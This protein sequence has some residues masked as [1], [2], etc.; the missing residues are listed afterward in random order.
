M[1]KLAFLPIAPRED[2]SCLCQAQGVLPT[3]SDLPH[4]RIHCQA[5]HQRGLV[6]VFRLIVTELPEDSSAPGVH[7]A[8]GADGSGVMV[9]AAELTE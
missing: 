4:R 2:S 1:A 9:A 7:S 6:S 8:F 5:F 3:A